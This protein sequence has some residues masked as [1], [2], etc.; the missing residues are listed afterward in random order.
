MIK[1]R[2]LTAGNLLFFTEL[3]V[4]PEDPLRLDD[5]TTLHGSKQPSIAMTNS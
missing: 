5:D 2:T 4:F 1:G 3:H